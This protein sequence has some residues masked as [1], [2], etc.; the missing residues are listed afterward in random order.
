MSTTNNAELDLALL[1][2]TNAVKEIGRMNYT[3]AI[4]TTLIRMLD[5]LERLEKEG[6]DVTELVNLVR[7]VFDYTTYI[8]DTPNEVPNA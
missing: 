8:T 2:V 4:K 3:L 1:Q 6:S 7:S 5:E